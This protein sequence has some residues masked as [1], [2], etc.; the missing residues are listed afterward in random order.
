M[1]PFA[2]LAGC[3]VVLVPAPSPAASA[4][5]PETVVL[6]HG[7]GRTSW[8]MSALARELE[9]AGFRVVNPSYPWRTQ[10][11]E[12]LASEWL[13][14]QLAALPPTPR[15]HLVTHSMGGLLVR[16]WLR[17]HSPP[18]QLGR[19]VMLAPPN[20]GSEIPDE[21][22]ASAPFRWLVGP[23]GPRLGTAAD[24]LPATL[25]PWPAPAIEL[26]I[27]AGSG[28]SSASLG[29]AVPAPHD[30]KVSV[31]STRLA[32]A[33]DHRVLPF[34]HTWMAWRRETAAHVAHFLR[35][36]RFVPES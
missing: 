13:P 12:Q 35:H 5:V 15:V 19:V 25:G 8:S 23:N 29:A 4:P 34:S 32:G 7:L 3:L 20:A 30:G 10:T 1:K 6:L 26:G 9:H 2:L 11:L 33:R 22:G 36:G 31:A 18:A 16:V 14:A 27:I 28:A 21:F 17:D 24:A